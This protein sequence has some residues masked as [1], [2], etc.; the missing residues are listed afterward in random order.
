MTASWGTYESVE[1]DEV[2]K[3]G[4][5]SGST[6]ARRLRRPSTIAIADLTPGH[7]CDRRAA[8]QVCLRID[9]Y[10]DAQYGRRA[11]RDRVV[12]RPGDP[13]DDPGRAMWMFQTKL[14]VDAGGA[15]VFLPVRDVLEQEWPE[16]DEEMRRLDLQYR[17]RLEFAIGRTCSVDWTGTRRVA[18]GDVRCG[19]RGCRW[20]R[21]RRPRRGRSR[22]RC[23]AWTR[24]SAG[25]PG[26]GAGRPDAAAR[27]LRDLAGRAGGCRPRSCRRICAR[28]PTIVALGGPAAHGTS[29]CRAGARRRRPGGVSLLP[30]HERGDA[31]SAHPSQVAAARSSDPTLSIARRTRQVERRE[32]GRRGVV[33]AVPAGV[34]PDAACAR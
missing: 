31:R 17:N 26:R 1:T 10:D 23:W 6:G 27:R 33:A 5:R 20:R 9:I 7:T 8:G 18:S 21:P 32:A 12:Q 3:R 28:L 19:R 15:E 34:H 16:H 4:G 11:D 14:Y 2:D 29:R 30:V 25:R 13:A 22:A 24:C